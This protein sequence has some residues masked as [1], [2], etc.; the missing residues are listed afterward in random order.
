M[1]NVYK[2][3]DD[4][5]ETIMGPEQLR[6]FL[7]DQL[8]DML[9]TNTKK[10]VDELVDTYMSKENTKLAKTLLRKFEKDATVLENV[11]EEF[12]IDLLK[13]RAFEVKTLEVY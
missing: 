8:R 2:V 13:T 12:L 6:G 4:S 5:W 9:C 11:S 7:F 10:E 1:M 3:Y